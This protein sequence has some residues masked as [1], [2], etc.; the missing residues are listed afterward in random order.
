MR[1]MNNPQLDWARPQAV[2]RVL[3]IAMIVL[4][5]GFAAAMWALPSLWWFAPL[6]IAFI[7]LM[8]SLNGGVRGLTELRQ[9]QLDER[10]SRT[11][12]AAF[13]KVYWPAL[14]VVFLGMFLLSNTGLT[15]ETRAAIGM[16]TFILVM[17]MPTLYLAWTLP[18]EIDAG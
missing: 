6:L 10:E 3:V 18:D 1:T 4:V 8:G 14:G 15:A 17:T 11:R 16:A 12:D 2:R 5:L 9:H 13:R 7:P